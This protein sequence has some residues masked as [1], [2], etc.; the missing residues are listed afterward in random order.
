MLA[1][2]ELVIHD[3]KR[4][5]KDFGATIKRARI[6]RGWVQKQL[7]DKL[8]VTDGY[9][10]KLEAGNSVPDEELPKPDPNAPP[11]P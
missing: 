4:G 5:L 3:P 1:N 11:S 7:G 6:K 9:I 2:V 10:T 8:G